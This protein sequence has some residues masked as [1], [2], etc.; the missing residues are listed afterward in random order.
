MPHTD[1]GK[2]FLQVIIEPEIII[3][4]NNCFDWNLFWLKLISSVFCKLE[5]AFDSRLTI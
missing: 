3:I 5:L 4:I 1:N 2:F